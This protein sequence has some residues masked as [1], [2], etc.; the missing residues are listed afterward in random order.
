MSSSLAP[1]SIVGAGVVYMPLN[2]Y[3]YFK[4][5]IGAKV[6]IMSTGEMDEEKK[7][8]CDRNRTFFCQKILCLMSSQYTYLNSSITEEEKTVSK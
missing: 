5:N 2:T 3:K 4:D 1:I 7:M 8:C 6:L